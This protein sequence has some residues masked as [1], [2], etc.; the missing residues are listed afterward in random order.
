MLKAALL[1]GALLTISPL[2]DTAI[3]FYYNEDNT[4]AKDLISNCPSLSSER[5]IPTPYLASG[6]SQ[7]LFGGTAGVIPGDS[8]YGV[9]IDYDRELVDLPD[10]GKLSID[11]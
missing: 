7:A 5:F 1:G 4:L 8:K 2:T 10:K 3:R 6:W 11:W 9:S